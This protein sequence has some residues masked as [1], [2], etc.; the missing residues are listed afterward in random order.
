[1]KYESS[2]QSATWWLTRKP[3][4]GMPMNPWP[5]IMCIKQDTQLRTREM[6]VT[7]S[8]HF[9]SGPHS[10]ISVS[11]ACEIKLIAEKTVK[12]Y[13]RGNR[14]G[15]K[16]SG[17]AV[18]CPPMVDIVVSLA[19]SSVMIIFGADSNA[20]KPVTFEFVTRI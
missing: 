4:N 6:T 9:S 12:A 2:D 17:G 18:G 5:K 16:T 20:L 1:M 11:V 19:S 3:S 15:Y 7:L 13:Q 10:L 8:T 14:D